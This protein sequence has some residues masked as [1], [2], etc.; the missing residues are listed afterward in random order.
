MCT[1]GT[2]GSTS[3][4]YLYVTLNVNVTNRLDASGN[5]TGISVTVMGAGVGP[6]NTGTQQL[7]ANTFSAVSVSYP[8]P[9]VPSSPVTITIKGI[10]AAAAMLSSSTDGANIINAAVVVVG[11]TTVSP[12][13]LPIAVPAST[14]QAS[15]L[16]N[17][18]PC[19][20]SPLPTT[21]DFPTFAVTSLSSA[22]RVTE[23][24][25][26]S[27]TPKDITS[28]TGFRILVNLSGYTP[29]ARV[30]VSDVIAG[31]DAGAATST[32]QFNSTIN[33]GSYTGSGQL[34]LLRV[35]GADS[36]GAG[37]SFAVGPPAVGTSFTSVSEISLTNGN[38]YVVYEV[39]DS[40]P[41]LIESA[42]IPL[43]LVAPSSVC[44][45]I[46]PL[47]TLSPMAAP[48]SNVTVGTATD[49][50]PR[51]LSTTPVSDCLQFNDCSA[52]YFPAL[53]VD[54]TPITFSA[55]SLGNRQ[56]A[57]IAVVN[58]GGGILNFTSSVA[59]DSSGSNWLA[60][61]PATG[62][63]TSA[64]NANLQ[65]IADPGTL[66]PGT[67]TASVTVNAGALGTA[68][69]PVTFV[70][71]P[72]GI[73]IQNVG[74]AASFQ[75]GSVAPGSYAALFGRNLA[76]T[77]VGVTFNGFPANVVFGN[78]TQINL[79]VPAGVASRA[80]A[81]VVVTVDGKVS[82]TFKVGIDPNTPG[83][84]S[85]G[86]VDFVGGAVNTAATPVTR[87]D[88]L[89][90]YLTGLATPVV[91]LTVNIGSLTNLIPS[92]AGAQGTFP[93]L[94]QVNIAVPLALP[95]SPNPV[96]F[97]VCVPDPPGVP[98]CSNPVNLYIK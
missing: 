58:S 30:F 75:F 48:V 86:I 19:L 29:G 25:L 20:G 47:P 67:Y 65:L 11:A 16:N 95:A 4:L 3:T 14:L 64:N 31:N 8:V 91:G 15:T 49:P 24:G 55:P 92:F 33:G 70:V 35:T 10:R 87:G 84:F 43:F 32:G 26:N 88:F 79:I 63:S 2:A 39:V 62:Q 68:T 56:S 59:F 74:N 60:V 40:N 77:N 51:F 83:I 97:T 57:L 66:A 1:G 80:A 50:I 7:S 89:V 17:G 44:T 94:D 13:S 6:V 22:V 5:P 85:N 53:S 28:D 34:I 54:M 71:G 81:D 82:N 90:V 96:P 73:T 52:S 61:T 72:V 27:F 21:L 18:V 93:A 69:V 9:A 78:A 37:G 46:T 98:A 38:G 42:Q 12:P 36:T 45:G 76:G 41:A 23:A